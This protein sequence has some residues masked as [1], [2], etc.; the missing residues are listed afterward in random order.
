MIDT[1]NRAPRGSVKDAKLSVGTPLNNRHCEAAEWRNKVI[2]CYGINCMY[3]SKYLWGARRIPAINGPISRARGCECVWRRINVIILT[4]VLFLSRALGRFYSHDD[5][6]L[7][8]HLL[9]SGTRSTD[10]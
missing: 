5:R 4:N 10:Y 9:S 6:V 2:T 8:R 1:P 7:F 3:I